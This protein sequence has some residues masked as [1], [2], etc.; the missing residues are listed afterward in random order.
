MRQSVQLIFN[1]AVMFGRIALTFGVGLYGT[2]LLINLLGHSDFGLLA[3]VGASGS[4]VLFLSRA[5]NIGAQRTLAHEIGRAD[6]ERLAQV[7]N[8]TFALF[9]GLGVVLLV[10]GLALKPIVLGAL[11]IPPGRESAAA[12]AYVFTLLFLA[13]ATLESPFQS[14]LEARQAMGLV[15]AFDTLRSLLHLGCIL[16]LFVVPWDLLVTYTALVLVIA[17]VRSFALA[18]LCAVRFPESR[19]R[20]GRIRTAEMARVARFAGWA[21]LLGVGGPLYNQ[22]SILLL[23]I[24][25]SPVITAA[26]A[27][28]IRIGGY[29][30]NFAG[31]VPRVVQ[32][33]MTTLEARGERSDVRRLVLMTGRYA[34]LAVLFPVVPLLLETES[35]LELWL[36]SVPAG[37][38]LYVRLVITALTLRVLTSGYERAVFS[39]GNLRPYAIVMIVLWFSGLASGA[40]ALVGLECGAWV[41]PASLLGVALVQTP[42]RIVLAGRLIDLEWTLWLRDSVGRTVVPAAIGTAAA[43]A[44]YSAMPVGWLRVVAVT[45]SY[46]AAAAPVIWL[47]SVDPPDKQALRELASRLVRRSVRE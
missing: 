20:P 23:A 2:R 40:F 45:S 44:A 12:G 37:T 32:P 10:V 27:I 41:L 16:L 8:S 38:A 43:F 28:A 1:F 11:Q 9:A 13:T 35:I 42:F 26:Y 4:L 47:F 46:A 17:L 21:T 7:F 22:A 24:A 19:P 31:V 33:A 15:A 14:V 30:L 5:L 36:G 29:H 3:G 39:H 6:R 34:A 18:T 25:T